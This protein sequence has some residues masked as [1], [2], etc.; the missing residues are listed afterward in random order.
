MARL[1]FF[2]KPGCGGNARQR[3]LLETA[4]S[5]QFVAALGLHRP[6]LDHHF[7]ADLNSDVLTG[8]RRF[9]A[10]RAPS[11]AKLK[12]SVRANAHRS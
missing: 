7:T 4:G 5:P 3:V 1:V 9:A 10:H 11:Q 12:R 2:E 6:S 8:A